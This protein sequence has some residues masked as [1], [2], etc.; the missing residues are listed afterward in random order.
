MHLTQAQCGESARERRPR[1]KSRAAAAL[2]P[3][4]PRRGAGAPALGL[5]HTAA[6]LARA[7]G[8]GGGEK[9]PAH[10]TALGTADR[11]QAHP[12]GVHGQALPSR[13]RATNA[14]MY[15]RIRPHRAKFRREQ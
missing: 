4:R 6:E 11:L 13:I 7:P 9:T 3:E 14:T 8:I 5:A 15:G 12:D 10:V 1:A 2:P